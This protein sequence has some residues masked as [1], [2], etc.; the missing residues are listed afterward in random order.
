MERIH[1]LYHIHFRER[2]IFLVNTVLCGFVDLYHK[3]QNNATMEALSIW[4]K[5]V[6]CNIRIPKYNNSE[7]YLSTKKTI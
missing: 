6:S 7:G 2:W 3:L 4:R 5:V 1:L